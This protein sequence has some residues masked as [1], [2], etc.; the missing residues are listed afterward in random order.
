VK[1]TIDFQP[2]GRRGECQ[3]GDSLLDCARSSGVELVNICGGGGTCGTCL[4]QVLEGSVSE[5]AEAEREFIPAEKLMQGYRLAC[6]TFPQSD[7]KIGVPPESLSTQQR[8]QVEGLET[9]VAPN[10]AAKTYFLELTPPSLSDLRS[11][12]DRLAEKLVEQYG[13]RDIAFD[14]AVLRDLARVLRANHWRVNGV[15]N[16]CEVTAV[17]PE[18]T[19][20]LGAAIDLGTTKIA[21][22]LMDL[23]TGQALASKGL[24]NPQISYGED[25][26]SRIAAAQD[27]L[28]KAELLR[29]L[30]VEAFNAGL[31]EMCQAC[32]QRPEQVVETVVV[33]N[34]AMHHLFLGLPVRQLGQAPY[35]PEICSALDIKGR[36]LG[37]HAAPGAWVHLLANI[38]GYV[39]GDHV[40]MLLACQV[41]QKDGVVLAIDIGTNTEICLANH[42]KLTSLSTASGPAF[43]GAH[44]Q[45]GM[46]AA[47]GAIERFQILNGENHYQTIDNAPATGICGSGILDI[48]A[49]LL[50]HGVVNR[51]G[52]MLAHPHVRGEGKDQEYLVVSKDA[53]GQEVSFTQKDIEQLQLAKGA[54]RTGIDVLL[55]RQGLTPD[56]IDQVIIAGAFG[57]YLDIGSAITIGMFPAVS[58]SKFRQVGNA[59]GM[60]AKLALISAD[61]R[62]EAREL[63]SQVAY[64][65]LAGDPNF[66]RVFANAMRLG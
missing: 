11:D 59:A 2:L 18:N 21:M 38:A 55:S 56:D 62:A 22:Y 12:A 43:E 35:V 51:R 60:G 1:Y 25:I 27:D 66:M 16:H 24:M 30:V 36:D 64:I 53:G 6:T 57:T 54:I 10:P 23:E 13:I 15:V 45:Y 5:I 63:A 41:H 47:A 42:G 49:Q 26:M 65:E 61:K 58:A 33:G 31:E 14:Y 52:R 32:G 44:I 34:T 9:P 3:A 4:V 29:N 20:T 17:L 28:K 40:A 46:R 8:T 7:C 37:L 50:I 19:K 48:L 39:G